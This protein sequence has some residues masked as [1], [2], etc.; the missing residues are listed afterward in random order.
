MVETLDS[1]KGCG[2]GRGEFGSQARGG[3][4]FVLVSVLQLLGVGPGRPVLIEGFRD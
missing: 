2:V 1:W 3:V 4:A